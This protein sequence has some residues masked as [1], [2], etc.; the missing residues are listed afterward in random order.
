MQ[1]QFKIIDNVKFLNKLNKIANKA[2]KYGY[3]VPEIVDSQELTNQ[4]VIIN[5]RKFVVNY[6]VYTID[7]EIFSAG[8]C[9]L[10]AKFDHIEN[11]IKTVPDQ[12]LPEQYLH[13]TNQ[14]DHCHINRQRNDTYLIRLSNG[15]YK[16]IGGN[17]LADYFNIDANVILSWCDLSFTLTDELTE[18]IE[19]KEFTNNGRYMFDLVETLKVTYYIIEKYGYISTKNAIEKNQT[20]TKSRVLDYF[21]DKDSNWGVLNQ[22]TTKA[23]IVKEYMLTLGEEKNEYLLTLYNLAVNNN[24]SFHSLGYAVSAIIAYNRHIEKNSQKE[25]TQQTSKG[26]YGKVGEKFTAQNLLTVTVK[27]ISKEIYTQYGVKCFY[28]LENKE[29]YV[30]KWYTDCDKLKINNTY[31]LTGTIKDHSQFN[32]EYYTEL[33]N[34][35]IK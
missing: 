33:T 32:G 5:D 22:Y 30:F 27:S 10:I 14:C 9:S 29:G 12:T 21:L 1:A 17:C 13:P 16:Q 20:A 24:C 6:T 3:S 4:T 15:E 7:Y 26:Y 28:T 23:Q 35:R 8:N 11:I 19:P 25:S 2:R 31:T 34:C 18:E